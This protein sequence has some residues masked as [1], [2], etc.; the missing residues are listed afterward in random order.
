MTEEP[1]S[2]PLSRSSVVE[3]EEKYITRRYSFGPLILHAHQYF[4]RLW[5]RNKKYMEAH[6]K[7]S[8]GIP[9][10]NLDNMDSPGLNFVIR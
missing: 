2:S 9:L 8:H 6:P 4:S 5:E 10:D 1:A 3:P 7:I